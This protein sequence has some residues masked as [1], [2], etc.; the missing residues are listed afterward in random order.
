MSEDDILTIREVA[1]LLKIGETTS[2]TMAQV[3]NCRASRCA[4]S[5]VCDA[6]TATNGSPG[7][8]AEERR[9]TRK[10]NRVE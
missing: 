1:V 10:E 9:A 4:G 6:P 7:R 8:S 3:G 5:G 2:D